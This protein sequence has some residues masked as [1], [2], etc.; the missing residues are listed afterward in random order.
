[1]NNNSENLQK[2]KHLLIKHLKYEKNTFNAL[3]NSMNIFAKKIQTQYNIHK[4]LKSKKELAS[5]KISRAYKSK[6]KIDIAQKLISD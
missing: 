6:M 4:T 3:E 1:M 5:T 2:M